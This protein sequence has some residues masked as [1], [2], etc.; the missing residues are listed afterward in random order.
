[1]AFRFRKSVRIAPGLRL[2]FSAK[3]GVSATVGGRGFSHNIGADGQRRTTVGIPGTGITHVTTHSA[4]RPVGWLAKIV[5]AIV[6]FAVTF[7][8]VSLFKR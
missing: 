6:V 1:M 7:F 2:N 8:V 4:S 3:R 5:A